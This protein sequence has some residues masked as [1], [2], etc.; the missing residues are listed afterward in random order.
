MF[1]RIA[2]IASLALLVSASVQAQSGCCSSHGGVCGCAC[3]DGTRLSDRCRPHFPC[4]GGGGAVPRGPSGLAAL[5]P[6][7]DSVQLTWLDNSADEISF[8]IESKTSLDIFFEEIGS[9]GANVTSATITGLLPRTT[10][11]FRVRARN[12]SGDSGYSNVTTITTPAQTAACAP[13]AVCFAGSRFKVEARWRTRDGASGSGVVVPLTDDSGYLW[14]FNASNVE[15]VF[16]VINA[17][18]VN[19]RYWFFAGGLTNVRVEITVTDTATGARKTYLNEQ[20][21]PFK[22]IQDT[23]AFATCP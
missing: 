15:A 16:K 21:T 11:S 17:C 5:A 7:G 12:G 19:Q 14:F 13:P 22:P 6:S 2:L 20:G 8:R 10:Y 9:V 18:A 1:R 4:G 3:C 23:T